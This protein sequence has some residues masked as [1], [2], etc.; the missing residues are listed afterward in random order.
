M[1]AHSTISIGWGVDL[2]FSAVDAKTDQ[3]L[4]NAIISNQSITLSDPS[5]ASFVQDATIIKTFFISRAYP[6]E[7]QL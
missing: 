3:Q 7:L 5:V 4:P 1:S 6:Q 2:T